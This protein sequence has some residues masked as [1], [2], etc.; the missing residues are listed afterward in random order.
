MASES[1]SKPAT[2]CCERVARIERRCNPA[3][4][5]RANRSKVLLSR[6]LASHIIVGGRD[7]ISHSHGRCGRTGN[8]H[9][10][11][12]FVGD[13]QLPLRHPAQVGH[14]SW[15]KDK[16]ISSRPR[17]SAAPLAFLPS[18][19][20]AT[21]CASTA[22]VCPRPMNKPSAP[23]CTRFWEFLPRAAPAEVRLAFKLRRLASQ[24]QA[25]PSR[26]SGT[27]F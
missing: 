17:F 2:T 10:K 21:P 7:R 12:W 9:H 8:L 4:C 23:A 1:F 6:L 3:F 25:R 16:R 18:F 22:I 20:P 13:K 24:R 11:G 19:S 14:P 5:A 27:G 15:T 26:T